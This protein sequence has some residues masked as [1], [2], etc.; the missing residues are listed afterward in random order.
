MR[1]KTNLVFRVYYLDT[2]GLRSST[3][4]AA[5]TPQEAVK[6]LLAMHEGKTVVLKTKLVK[7]RVA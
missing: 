1:S 5:N 2:A 7:E 6:A 3:E 4:I